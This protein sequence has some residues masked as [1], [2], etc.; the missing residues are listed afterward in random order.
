M[1]TLKAA[2]PPWRVTVCTWFGTGLLRPAPG[3]WGTLVAALM[4]GAALLL[5]GPA[6]GRWILIAGVLAV[7]AAGVFC[8]PAAIRHFAVEDPSEVVVDEVAGVWLAMAILPTHLLATPILAAS[9]A[10]LFFR[11]FD[12][13]KPWPVTWCEHLPGGWGIMADDLAA[14]ALAGCL[15]TALLG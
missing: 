3:T 15:A 1:S 10:F 6:N 2:L 12:I 5:L 11:V 13:A 8:A 7:S 4:A 9:A 14:G